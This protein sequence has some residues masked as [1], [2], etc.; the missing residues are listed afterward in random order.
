[1]SHPLIEAGS[2]RLAQSRHGMIE[3]FIGASQS[4]LFGSRNLLVSAL[5][6]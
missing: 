3:I 5:E 6:L 4:L 2:F 1:M